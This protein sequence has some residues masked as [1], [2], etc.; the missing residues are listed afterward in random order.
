MNIL[1]LSQLFCPFTLSIVMSN[2]HITL[3]VC[4]EELNFK[5]RNADKHRS[6]GVCVCVHPSVCNIMFSVQSSTLCK[7][8]K[9]AHPRER[10]ACG[11]TNA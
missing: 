4:K 8:Q 2:C 3:R 9:K 1:M 10:G 5:F 6:V 11:D 7:E